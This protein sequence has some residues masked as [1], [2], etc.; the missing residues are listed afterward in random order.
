M[1]LS[2]NNDLNSLVSDQNFIGSVVIQS[3]GDDAEDD[4]DS[5]DG[6]ANFESTGTIF[7]ITTAL[8]IS[9]SFASG[10]TEDLRKY[11][12]NKCQQF[13]PA[14][15]KA[16][17]EAALDSDEQRLGFLINERFVNI[18]PQISVPLLENLHKE[19][20]RAATKKDKFSFTHYAML[21]KFYRKDAKKSKNKAND[22]D[23]DIYSNGEEEILCEKCDVSFEYNVRGETDSGLSGNWTESDRTLTPYRRLILFEAAKLPS[24]IESIKQAINEEN[25][26]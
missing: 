12:R 14:E 4:E 3:F 24:I 25:Q 15:S 18:P 1:A 2:Q 19:I 26:S 21:V 22:D 6:D 5:D 9:K 13:A 20:T 16:N 23:G 10:C 17:F 8:N 11:I 7:G